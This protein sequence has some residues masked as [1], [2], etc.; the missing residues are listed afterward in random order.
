MNSIL[1]WQ[2]L[3]EEVDYALSLT[4]RLDVSWISF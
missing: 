2:M 1:I 3:P 4:L